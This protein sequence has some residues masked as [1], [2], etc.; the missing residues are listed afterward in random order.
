MIDNTQVWLEKAKTLFNIQQERKALEKAEQD[1]SQELRA[2]QGHEPLSYGGIKYYYEIRTGSVDYSIIP[3]LQSV[4]LELY[5][6]GPSKVW[7][8]A[9]E[10]VM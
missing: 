2:L 8:L 9:I 5:R 7:K 1:L 3:E 4:D 10:K 6:K